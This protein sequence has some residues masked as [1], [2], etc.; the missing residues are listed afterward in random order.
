MTNFQTGGAQ[1]RP[2]VARPALNLARLVELLG[3]VLQTAPPGSLCSTGDQHLRLTTDKVFALLF[4]HPDFKTLTDPGEGHPFI[5]NFPRPAPRSR[6]QMG[7][8][9]PPGNQ[10]RL[11]RALDR[12]RAAIDQELTAALP[13]LPTPLLQEG[14][15]LRALATRLRL[16]YRFPVA[17]PVNL[18]PL[19]L[20]TAAGASQAGLARL[21]TAREQVETRDHFPAMVRAIGHHLEQGRDC[22]PELVDRA[23]ASLGVQQD[24][25]TSQ[26]SSFWRFLEE[27]VLGRI[28]LRIG[29][30]IMENLA[31]N[32]PA[33][34]CTAHQALSSYIT[35]VLG[36]FNL[37]QQGEPEMEMS[38]QYGLR[39]HFSLWSQVDQVGFSYCLPVWIEPQAQMFSFQALGVEREVSYRFRVNGNNPDSG[40]STFLERLAK[41]KTALLE[42][43]GKVPYL[44][45]S[46][47][48]LVFLTLALPRGGGSLDQ[49]LTQLLDRLKTEG[50]GLVRE[51]L[52]DLRQQAGL[53]NTIARAL[54]EV[55]RTKGR[56]IVAQTRTQV[57]EQF[58]CVQ[59]GIVNW[60]RLEGAEPG[61]KDLLIQATNPTHSPSEWLR[62]VQIR[63]R[64]EDQHLLFAIKVVTRIAEYDLVP[65]GPPLQLQIQRLP[66]PQFLQVGWVPSN[67]P[68]VTRDWLLPGAVRVEYDYR[69]LTRSQ[70]QEE[71]RQRAQAHAVAITAF[72]V[73]VYTCLDCL[74]AHLT[75][76][77]Q[78]WTLLMLRFQ[79]QGQPA[80]GG[81][82]DYVYAAAKA[83]SAALAQE[84]PTFCQGVMIDNLDPRKP[85]TKYVKGGAFQALACAF[86]LGISTGSLPHLAKLGLVSY[87]YRPCDE[88]GQ[89]SHG[90]ENCLC[91]TQS[92]SATAIDTP[93]P[94]YRL[95]RE[96]RGIDLTEGQAGLQT[97]RLVK[98]EISRLASLGCEHI[99]LLAHT[100]REGRR[101]GL[102][103][104]PLQFLREVYQAFPGLV[105]YPL[106]RDVFPVTRL[107]RRTSPQAAFEVPSTLDHGALLGGR[108]GPGVIPI[109]SFATLHVAE[110]SGRPQ[111]GFC[112]YSWVDDQ[113]LGNLNNT[114]RPRRH[115]LDP[116]GTSPVRPCILAM[117]RGVHFLEAQKPGPVLDPFPWVSPST[118]GAVGEVEFLHGTAAGTIVL[119]Y[120]AVLMHISQ[121]LHRRGS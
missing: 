39:G 82:A 13:T 93:W 36:L 97:Q 75:L 58:I 91:C 59:R 119:S 102:S 33:N 92:Y 14:D 47:A 27:Q 6:C 85:T 4:Q 29:N 21:I 86:P 73:L 64:P 110:E 54:V 15:Q 35:R 37:V 114:E 101:L 41:I 113:Q 89:A 111:S 98:E 48:Q 44:E 16:A 18:T 63:S 42:D 57:R 94:G 105:I 100:R 51:L 1:L 87:A 11:P 80:P 72:T 90:E 40:Q 17:Q 10:E 3:E 53:V 55:L 96:H 28:R 30:Q 9:L 61:T 116:E 84:Q 19:K 50:R 49:D 117:L 31:G 81:G 7:A 56:Q 83:I 108:P 121:V 26:L 77:A 20:Q 8:T 66:T 69:Y 32:I 76:K 67:L 12:L 79:A 25:P 70:P 115:L 24:D 99:M 78:T 103:P 5:V 52:A 62:Q 65:E 71:D 104:F 46:L 34:A 22:E 23:C 112:M 2:K 45:S 60:S 109:Y 43:S 74:R 88:L 95:Q 38:P 107:H 120:P 118:I 68:L 106:L